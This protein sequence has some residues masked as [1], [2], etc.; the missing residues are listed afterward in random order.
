MRTRLETTP[1]RAAD[2]TPVN[3]DDSTSLIRAGRM[4]LARASRITAGLVVVCGIVGGLCGLLTIAPLAVGQF[5]HP[6]TDERFADSLLQL[7]AVG[8]GAGGIAGAVLGPTIAWSA[9]RHVPLWRLVLEPA[10]GTVAGSVIAWTIL[11]V[12]GYG[13]PYYLLLPVVGMFVA[14]LR[15][16]RAARAR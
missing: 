15:L 10:I 6:Y 11:M 9:L 1:R 8:F 12:R 14:A 4:T 13:R 7:A 16:R 2:Q 3:A 5:L